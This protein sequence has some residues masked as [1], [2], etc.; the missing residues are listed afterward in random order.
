M[1]VASLSS[2]AGQPQ[3]SG[4]SVSGS[5]SSFLEAKSPVISEKRKM[6]E[7]ELA[8]FPFGTDVSGPIMCFTKKSNHILRAVWG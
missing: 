4:E 2:S 8:F 6:T 1:P 3:L 7:E 5:H